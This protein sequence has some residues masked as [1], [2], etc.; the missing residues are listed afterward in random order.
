MS[1]ESGALPPEQQPL[2]RRRRAATRGPFGPNSQRSAKRA[3]TCGRRLRLP[4][5]IRAAHSIF[6]VSTRD[7]K[8]GQADHNWPW[9][10]GLASNRENAHA[11]GR[12]A[13]DAER[14]GQERFLHDGRC[15]L[16]TPDTETGARKGHGAC[17]FPRAFDRL[18]AGAAGFREHRAGRDLSLETWRM[19]T[20]PTGFGGSGGCAGIPLGCRASG[21]HPRSRLNAEDDVSMDEI[22]LAG[23][24][25]MPCISDI[26]KWA[27]F[28]FKGIDD[29]YVKR[30]R[31]PRSRRA[32]HDRREDA[33]VIPRYLG[34]DVVIAQRIVRIH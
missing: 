4:P 13:V 3:A 21:G 29:T 14:M 18:A 23:A 30:A 31:E 19:G 11:V 7:A 28:A 22:I 17:P 24:R 9:I 26:P 6:V 8:R 27:E 2:P 15:M 1:I 16:S 34:L 5:M 20:P 33:T 32:T 10:N 25:V 12:E